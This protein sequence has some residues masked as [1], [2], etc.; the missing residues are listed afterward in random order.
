[1]D[2]LEVSVQEWRVSV[3]DWKV[4]VELLVAVFVEVLYGISYWE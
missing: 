4:L 1:M 2:E 3:L